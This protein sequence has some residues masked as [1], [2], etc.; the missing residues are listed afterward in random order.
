MPLAGYAPGL[1]SNTPQIFTEVSNFIPYEAGYEAAPSLYD[2]GANAL[3]AVAQAAHTGQKVD[4]AR[5]TFAATATRIYELT[6][7]TTWTDRSAGGAAYTTSTDWSFCQFGDDTLASNYVDTIQRSTSGAFAAIAYALKAKIV[8]SV[9]TSGGGFT[10]AANTSDATYGV[11]PDRWYCSALNNGVDFVVS[12]ATQCTTGR[13]IG[14]G[15]DITAAK[16]FGADSIVIYKANALFHGRYVGGSTVWSFQE[17]PNVGCAG[18][19]A[20]ANLGYAHF[21]VA[22]DGFWMYD[23]SVPRQVGTQEI[24]QYFAST[25][26]Q[27]NLGKTEVRFDQLKNRVLVFYPVGGSTLNAVLV[28]HLATKQWGKLAATVQTTLDYVPS[29]ISFDSDTGTFDTADGLLFDDATVVPAVQMAGINS[30]NKLTTL[31]GT[32]GSSYVQ[33]HDIGDPSA[34][35]RLTEAYAIYAARP[36]TASCSLYSSRVLGG[37]E[38]T[39]PTQTA[40]DTPL[41]GTPGRFTLRQHARY[42]RIQFNFTGAC[43]LT[44]FT[45]KISPAGSR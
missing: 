10:F 14:P 28:Y 34:M 22:Q 18:K 26:S 42:H 5:R 43:Q 15:G 9:Q 20:V 44:D 25:V 38:L 19:R 17:V 35:S 31:N 30:S 45:A 40:Y 11:S 13:L 27:L 39:G 37:T 1:P 36:T 29:E 3:A 23:G 32:P 33:T 16:R 4:G 12:T 2:I 7:G 8:E 21:I 6:S 41:T 24:R